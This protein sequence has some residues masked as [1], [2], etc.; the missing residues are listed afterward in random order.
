[1]PGEQG[2]LAA[3]ELE[4]YPGMAED[5]IQRVAEEA[6]RR[7]PLHGH[8]RHPPL[9][10]HPAGRGYRA[11]GRPRRPT[12]QAAFA[13]AD[14]IMDYLKTR[15]PFWK[16][17]HGVDGSEGDWVEARDEDDRAADRWIR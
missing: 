15:A 7:W 16:K 8:H 12:A 2:R 4:H 17:E 1:M 3:L 6:A 10:P 5:E 13:A 14:F 11:C 9:R